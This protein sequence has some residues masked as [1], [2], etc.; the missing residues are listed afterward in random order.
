MCAEQ[1]ERTRKK[2]KIFRSVRYVE[3]ERISRCVADLLQLSHFGTRVC[4]S[5]KKREEGASLRVSPGSPTHFQQQ[6]A[7]FRGGRR[8]GQKKKKGAAA[9]LRATAPSPRYHLAPRVH[10][11]SLPTLLNPSSSTGYDRRAGRT[12]LFI[13]FARTAPLSPI[14]SRARHSTLSPALSCR[15]ATLSEGSWVSSC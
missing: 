9:P 7:A 8:R 14:G 11:S 2:S 6:T 15:R 12:S 4:A 3:R 5:R 13:G 10:L 1:N